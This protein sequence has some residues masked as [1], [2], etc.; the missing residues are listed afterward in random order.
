LD[1]K[2]GNNIINLIGG[3]K[4]GE[5]RKYSKA[6]KLLAVKLYYEKKIGSTTIAKELDIKDPKTVRHWIKEYKDKGEEAFGDTVDTKAILEEYTKISEL[7][8]MRERIEELEIE[9]EYLKKLAIYRKGM[10]GSINI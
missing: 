2:R 8:R 7:I 3:I 4:M 1:K 6:I 10:R 5:Q 9:N